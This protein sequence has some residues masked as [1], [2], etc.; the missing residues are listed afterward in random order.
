[1]HDTQGQ[2]LPRCLERGGV[3]FDLYGPVGGGAPF[4]LGASL[5]LPSTP[6]FWLPP[7]GYVDLLP[8]F[9]GYLALL[10]GIAGL[11]GLLRATLGDTMTAKVRANAAGTALRVVRR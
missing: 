4:L 11:D 1:M 3:T 2:L 8:G 9:P 7:W 5:A 6:P 10:D